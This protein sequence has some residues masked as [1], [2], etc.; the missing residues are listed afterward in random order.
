VERR[1][2]P[3]KPETQPSPAARALKLLARREHTRRELHQKLAPYV[4]DA[5][6]LEALLDDFAARGW[7]SE[8]RVVEQV[9]HAK[10]GRLGIARIRHAL[11][12]RGVPEELIQPAL[13]KLRDSELDTARAIW[14]GKFGARPESRAEQ[15]R[16]VRFLQARGFGMEI[17]MRVVRGDHESRDE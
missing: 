16:Q 6:E 11:L 9:V 8:A 17:A 7:I 4:E 3:S 12:E 10:R 13:Q 2:R 14:S 15:A 1:K 5:E